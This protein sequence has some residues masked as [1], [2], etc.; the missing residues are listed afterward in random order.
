MHIQ[1]R[2]QPLLIKPLKVR[3]SPRKQCAQ[4]RISGNDANPYPSLCAHYSIGYCCME[5]KVIKGRARKQDL[6]SLRSGNFLV[7]MVA[8]LLAR[9]C[10]GILNSIFG[11]GSLLFSWSA[12]RLFGFVP[13]LCCVNPLHK[14]TKWPIEQ[15]SASSPT[16]K[17]L[18]GIF[19]K[20]L[21]N[22]KARYNR[23]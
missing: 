16:I 19:L 13:F 21:T 1:I 14:H 18:S 17:Q 15:V 22:F 4:I 23:G 20:Y 3:R 10:L 5:G 12:G 8:L 7:A 6:R 9:V 2:D 11:K